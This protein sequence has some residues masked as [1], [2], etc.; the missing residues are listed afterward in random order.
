[1]TYALRPFVLSVLFFT[2]ILSEAAQSI[3]YV[4]SVPGNQL[5]W[6]LA[7]AVTAANGSLVRTLP[8][9][10]VA[11]AVSS[12]TSF[13]QSLSRRLGIMPDSIGPLPARRL[14]V[15]RVR[16][17][18]NSPTAADEFYRAGKQWGIMR[19]RANLAWA[20]GFSGSHNTIVAVIDTGVAWNHPDLKPNV[21]FS[22]CYTSANRCSPYPPLSDHGTHVAGIIAAAFGGG[23][24]VGVGPKL[25][26]ASYNTFELIDDCGLCSYDDSRWAAMMDAADRGF[27]VINLSV[28]STYV[29]GGSNS[30]EVVA[31]KAAEKKVLNYVTH[32]GSLVVASAG[33]GNRNL[34]GTVLHLPGDTP[35][36]VNVGATAIRPVPRYPTP[37]TYDVRTYYSNY[38]ASLTLS[39]PGGDCGSDLSCDP[40]DDNWDDFLIV[41]TI[42]YVDELC[43]ARANCPIGYDWK[44]GT[45][46]AAA[47]VSGVAGIIRDA[48]RELKPHHVSAILKNTA[49]GAGA[50]L[51]FG[52]G[53]VDAF[54]AVRTVQQK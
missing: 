25:G 21:V 46:M 24:V 14:P 37:G 34:S 23:S 3:R 36:F 49:D 2:P 43:A 5:P 10:G 38:G 26:L 44:S 22:T 29:I 35:G 9:V 18:R 48:R 1:M 54:E 27:S 39:A 17:Q 8:K 50:R 45:S 16:E 33:N 20:A 40:I 28:G 32:A 53:I 11:I 52:H 15:A 7:E 41:S 31:F 13:A 6:G 51:Q 4:I 42:V 19:V 30:H 12:N 47:H